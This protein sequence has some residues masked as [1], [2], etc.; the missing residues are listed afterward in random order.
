[1]RSSGLL[2]GAGGQRERRNDGGKSELRLHF[3]V[4]QREQVSGIKQPS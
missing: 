1:L 4:P 3:C 2:L